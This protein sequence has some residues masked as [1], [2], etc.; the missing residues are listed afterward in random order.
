MRD[1]NE[2]EAFPNNIKLAFVKTSLALAQH[3]GFDFNQN[4]RGRKRFHYC[5]SGTPVDNVQYIDKNLRVFR[6]TYTVGRDDLALAELKK[7]EM[8]ANVEMYNRSSFLD[9]CWNCPLGGYCGGGCS[10]STHVDQSRF[11]QEEQKNFEY[12]VQEV[13]LPIVW[14]KFNGVSE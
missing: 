12:L 10:V 8:S 1:F 7:G 9:K 13:I 4:E 2:K 3:F 6:C 14:S 11:C 5:W